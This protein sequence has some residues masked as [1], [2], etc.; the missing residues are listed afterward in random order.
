MFLATAA[1]GLLV[2]WP[3]GHVG[4]VSGPL[5]VVRAL[6]RVYVLLCAAAAALGLGAYAVGKRAPWMSTVLITVSVIVPFLAIV[7]QPRQDTSGRFALIITEFAAYSAFIISPRVRALRTYF[8]SI[9]PAVAFFPAAAMTIG[10]ILS[11]NAWS[12]DVAWVN[13]QLESATAPCLNRA[14]LSGDALANQYDWY[15]LPLSL[16]EQGLRPRVILTTKAMCDRLSQDRASMRVFDFDLS[17]VYR[18]RAA[19][20]RMDLTKAG[21]DGDGAGMQLGVLRSS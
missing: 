1:I 14:A 10:L 21:L 5:G 17:A 9:A 8:A 13:T 4:V 6:G 19:T 18:M 12:S 20:G 3:F 7:I 11:G 15:T 16:I 2:G